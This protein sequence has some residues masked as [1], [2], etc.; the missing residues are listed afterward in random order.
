MN[1]IAHVCCSLLLALAACGPG[2]GSTSSGSGGTGG[3]GTGGTDAGPHVG[4]CKTDMDCRSLCADGSCVLSGT[5]D[6]GDCAYE[7]VKPTGTPCVLNQVPTLGA[8]DGIACHLAQ[9]HTDADCTPTYDLGFCFP[10]HCGS[11]GACIN[12]PRCAA[13]N[14]CDPEKMM[15]IPGKCSINGG[16]CGGP[17]DM[18]CCPGYFCV[19]GECTSMPPCSAMAGAACDPT[20]T[21]GV[22]CCAVGL[23]CDSINQCI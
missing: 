18:S 8:C 5:S 4:D 22:T 15:C 12:A 2:N 11:A 9:C 3:S 7:H 23:T 21:Q 1:R 19:Q 13:T 10:S 20:A 16:T 17:G 6:T 14:T